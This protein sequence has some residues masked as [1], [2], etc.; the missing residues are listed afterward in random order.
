MGKF[1]ALL[2]NGEYALSQAP[3]GPIKG[4]GNTFIFIFQYDYNYTVGLIFFFVCNKTIEIQKAKN[5][6]KITSKSHFHPKNLF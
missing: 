5:L 1:N 6:K 2:P 4:N 3:K